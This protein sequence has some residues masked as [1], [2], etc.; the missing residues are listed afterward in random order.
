MASAGTVA[1][2]R[3]RKFL[4][5]ALIAIDVF[6]LAS[7]ANEHLY[8]KE[9]NIEVQDFLGRFIPMTVFRDFGTAERQCWV[10]GVSDR[11]RFYGCDGNG[12]PDEFIEYLKDA[13]KNHPMSEAELERF[14][15]Y[16]CNNKQKGCKNYYPTGYD[17]VIKQIYVIEFLISLIWG[18]GWLL[19][20]IWAIGFIPF[21]LSRDKDSFLT[22]LFFGPVIGSFI[23]L[24]IAWILEGLSLLLGYVLGFIVWANA[25]ALVTIVLVLREVSKFPAEIREIGIEG[26]LSK[27]ADTKQKSQR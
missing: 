24:P 9:I 2:F 11:V 4:Y 6:L 5:L 15:T 26:T 19:L 20:L 3:Q 23:V 13:N 16:L 7:H 17:W 22:Y 21:L 1:H 8:L 14:R 10:A 12:N 25:F 27:T 18:N